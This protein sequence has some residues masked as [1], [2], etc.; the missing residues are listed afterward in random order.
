MKFNKP[1]KTFEEQLDLLIGRGMQVSDRAKAVHYLSH[2]NYYRL[3]AYWLPFEASHKP[4]RFKENTTFDIVLNHYL[5][6]RELRLHLLDAIERLE[7][8]FRTQ[9]AYCMSQAYGSHGYLANKH[10]LRKNERRFLEDIRELKEHIHRSDEVFIKH[11]HDTYD[12]EA[13]PT[14]VS[15]EV[16]SLGLLSRLYSNL[17]AYGIRRDIAAIYQVDE[18]FLEGFLEHLTYVR[19]VCAHHSRLW[20]RHLSKK[21]P[22]PKGKPAGLRDS[23]YVDAANKTEHKIY[24]TFVVVQHLLTVISPDST[25]AKQLQALINKY[26]ID[27][28]HMGFPE[29]WETLPLWQ[30]SFNQ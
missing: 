14:W 13:P 28:K 19:N 24:N 17:R 12:E 1:P 5:F 6:D 4:H 11:Y 30:Q 8:S 21:M 20:N 3:A 29:G 15:C 9:W 23:T 16:I 7:V 22:L 18:G 2:I 10:G 25:W 27:V 26:S